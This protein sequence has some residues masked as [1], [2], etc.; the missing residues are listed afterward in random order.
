MA[1]L[2]WLW[3]HLVCIV[4]SHLE[5]GTAQKP[6]FRWLCQCIHFP[7]PVGCLEWP[8]GQRW[9]FHIS[10]GLWMSTGLFIP[11]DH[12]TY[13]S[14]SLIITIKVF[15]GVFH[16]TESFA[17]PDTCTVGQGGLRRAVIRSSHK[18]FF[19]FLGHAT[20]HFSRRALHRLFSMSK[21]PASPSS[22]S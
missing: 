3:A 6:H 21:W 16:W 11:W 1:F 12:F 13:G 2:T 18:F 20:L 9:G 8:D 5:V 19:P 15:S 17:H 10:S 14:Y 22:S 4:V 7:F